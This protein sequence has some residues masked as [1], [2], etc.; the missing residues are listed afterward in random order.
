MNPLPAPGTGVIPSRPLIIDVPHI[1]DEHREENF[2]AP[3]PKIEFPTFNG[4]NPKLWQQQCETYFEVFR[5]H[6][7]LR[8]SYAALGFQGNA[9]LWFQSVE[10]AG[11]VQD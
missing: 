9:A 4:E 8:T 6:P 1:Q 5:V 2:R 10:A 11:R 3:A 7:S